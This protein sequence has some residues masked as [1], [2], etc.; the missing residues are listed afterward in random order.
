MNTATVHKATKAEVVTKALVEAARQLEV[1]Q[2]EL[3]TIL[4]VSESSVSRYKAGT[5]T[6]DARH[7]VTDTAAT[8]ILIYRSLASI[9]GSNLDHMKA[10]LKSHNDDLGDVP[11]TMMLRQAGLHQVRAYLDDYRG[12][13]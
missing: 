7:H 2:T 6:I 12:R 11:L 8:F 3:A 9:L 1:K 10:W 4:G 13:C 5:L